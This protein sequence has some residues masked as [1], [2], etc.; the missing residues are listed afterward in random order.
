M[1]IGLVADVHYADKEP[2]GE[3]HYRDS[4]ARLSSAIAHFN[5]SKVDFVVELGDFID[6]APSANEELDYLRR[7]E[8]VYAQARCPRFHVLGNHC[9]STLT[10]RQFLA[11]CGPP[12]PACSFD[13]GGFHFVILDA[14]F[15]ENG[16]PYGNGNSVWTDSNIPPGELAWLTTELTETHH[17]TVVFV[18][19][20]L[21]VDDHYGVR[22]RIEV[23]RRLE[24]SGKVRAVFQG[25]NHK[26]DFTTIN[27]I[28]YCTLPAMVEGDGNAYALL[29]LGASGA[30]RID[31]CGRQESRDF[32]PLS[33]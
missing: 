23:R 32:V 16:E 17:P 26:N 9:V 14:C 19:Q 3:R 12:G 4:L 1:Q 7:I 20:R 8:S 5:E 13:F 2:A 25:H 11:E 28:R 27:G 21:D 15:R 22:Q 29:T 33:T 6:A 10:K 24:A 31:G 18:H 30:M